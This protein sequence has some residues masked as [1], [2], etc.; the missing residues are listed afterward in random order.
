MNRK[1]KKVFTII[2]LTLLS[3]NIVSCSKSLNKETR[4]DDS[5]INVKSEDEEM[6][7]I[8]EQARQ[9]ADKFLKE[10]N[11][12]N[13]KAVDFAIKYPF[14]TDPGSEASK[15]HMW[16]TNIEKSNGKYYGI[17]ANDS[18]YIKNMKMGQKVE[19][20]MNKI[21]DWKYVENGFLVGGKSIVYF[22]NQ[23]SEQEKKNFE[24]EAGFKI[25]DK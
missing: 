25:K 13:T 16:I 17:I 8:I 12:P 15:E 10:L 7:L 9:T 24:K 21:S 1:I 5:V 19:F 4:G 14:D 23:M 6:N 18:F 11:N 3:F 2:L 22:Y 20:N